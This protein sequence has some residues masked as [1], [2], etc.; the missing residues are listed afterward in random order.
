MNDKEI[1]YKDIDCLIF[2]LPEKEIESLANASDKRKKSI[3]YCHALKLI[4]KHEE[5]TSQFLLDEKGFLVIEDGGIEKY[6]NKVRRDKDLDTSIKEL[7]YDSLRKELVVA[8][9]LVILG[10]ALGYVPASMSEDKMTKAI[11]LLSTSIE[12][13]TNLNSDFQNEVQQMYL[14]ID[15]LKNEI[16]SLKTEN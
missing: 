5:Y 7:T 11:E 13:S 1:D 14:E 3:Y 16:D 6:L 8:V 9:F 10:T 15:S 2:K 4:R 12:K